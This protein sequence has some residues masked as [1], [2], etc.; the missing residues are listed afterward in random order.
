MREQYPDLEK[1]DVIGRIQVG[2]N[3]HIGW[4][5]IIMLGVTIGDNCVIGCGAVVTRD[6]PD[7]SVVAGVPAKVIKT[8]GEYADKYRA[9]MV[10][11]TGMESEEKHRFLVDQGMV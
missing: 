6:V 2:N 10:P 1:A 7:D 5:A 9:S 3:V 4:N 11:T 8:I